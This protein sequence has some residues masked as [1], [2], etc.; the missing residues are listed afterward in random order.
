MTLLWIGFVCMILF[1]LALD[2]GVL[3]REDRAVSIPKAL[4]WTAIWVTLSLLFGVFVYFQYE[5]NLVGT[6]ELTL[7][8]SGREAALQYLSAYLLEESLSLDNMFVIALILSYFKIPAIYQHRV[9]FWGILGAIVMRG[10]VI[11]AGMAL[12][13]RLEWMNYVFGAIL[14]I[15]AFKLLFSNDEAPDME[16]SWLVR[17]CRKCMPLTLEFHGRHFIAVENNKWLVTPLGFVLVL[18]NFGDLVFAVDSIPAVFAV[19]NDPFIAFTS[20]IFAVLGLRSLY[21]VL[22][23]VMDKFRYLRHSLVVLLFFIGSK[24]IM[25]LHYKIPVS[26]SLVIIVSVLGIG[27]M[28]SL[29]VAKKQGS[30][31]PGAG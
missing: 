25:S 1:F 12:L 22:A 31:R 6:A 28:V 11:I 21:F 26:W 15:T 23:G 13:H 27:I 14:L 7:D 8:L 3:N 16:Q 5:Y 19:T 30:V 2:L 17:I 24:M 9:L 10:T 18:V 29:L 4:A 20:N